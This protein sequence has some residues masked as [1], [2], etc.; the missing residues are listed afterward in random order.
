MIKQILGRRQNDGSISPFLK[1]YDYVQDLNYD[2]LIETNTYTA[3]DI[4][5]KCV[6]NVDSILIKVYNES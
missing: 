2:L 6:H 1:S 5:A 4:T 3:K